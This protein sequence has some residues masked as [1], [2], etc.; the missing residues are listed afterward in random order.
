MGADGGLFSPGRSALLQS[1]RLEGVAGAG[2]EGGLVGGASL[3]AAPRVL[4]MPAGPGPSHPTWPA[5]MER[6]TRLFM[7]MDDD[8]R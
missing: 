1:H 7:K 8:L 2:V 4:A 5:G 6:M 3:L